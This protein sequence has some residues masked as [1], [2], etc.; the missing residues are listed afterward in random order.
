[1]GPRVDLVLCGN[2]Q[3]TE[4]RKT[5]SA[6]SPVDLEGPLVDRVNYRHFQKYLAGE[7]DCSVTG[8]PSTLGYVP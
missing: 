2:G 5:Q 4:S 1:M 8:R 7:E 3:L 6:V